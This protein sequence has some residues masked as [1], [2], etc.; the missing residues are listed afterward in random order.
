MLFQKSSKSKKKWFGKQKLQTSDPSVEIDTALPLPPPEDIKLTDIENQNNHHNVAE[1]TTV[2]DVE[3]PVRSVQTAVVKTQAATVSRFAGKPKDEVAA[4][5]IQTAFRG[6]LVCVVI[7]LVF[8]FVPA[9]LDEF[10]WFQIF[11]FNEDLR[12]IQ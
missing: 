2:V 3:E 8:K 7:S 12:G 11:Y 6:Y 9:T 5:K 10:F 1:I 4:I